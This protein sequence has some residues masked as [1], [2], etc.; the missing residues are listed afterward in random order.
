M[1][2]SRVAVN[3]KLTVVSSR[4]VSASGKG[5]AHALSALDSAMGSHTVHVIYYYKN[6]EKWFESFDLLD[7]LRESLSE[8]LTLYPTVT[9]RLGKRGVD[10]GWEVK[11]NDAGVRVIKASVDAT[12]DQWLKSASGSEENLLVAWDHMP[13]DPTTWSPFR[14]Q[15]NRFEG[16]GVA[17]GISCSHMVADLTFLASF[18]KSWTEVHRHLAIT[19]PPFVAPLPN[20]ADDDAESLPRHAK[21]HSPRNMATATFKFSSSIIN[22]C[23]SKVHGTC[24]NATPFD[25]LAA[26]FWNRIARVKPPKNHHQ[27]HCL[28][29]C[30][31]F[32]NLI[33]ASLPIG[34]FGNALHFSMLSQKVE[35]MQLGGIVS[36]VHSHLKGLSEEEIWSTNNEGNYYCMYGTELTCVCMEHLVFEEENESLLYAAMFGNNEKPIQVSCRVGNVDYG[37]GLITVMPS[38]EGGLSRTVMVMLPEEELAELSKDEAILELE[39]AMLL[40]GSVVSGGPLT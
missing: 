1:S 27:T 11:C 26:L 32:R 23:L 34:Y 30:T 25:F 24:P 3:S 40:A 36:A 9:G 20:H 5:K 17:I 2:N 10:G 29:I 13:D 39:P 14:I 38:E 28:C 21:T 37:E 4:P 22:R 35:D 16:G 19:H 15:V 12:L 8:V 31:D 7:P 6:E 33:K 18:F